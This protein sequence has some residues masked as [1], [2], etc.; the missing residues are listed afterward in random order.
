[1]ATLY[2][3]E[4]RAQALDYSG[5]AVPVGKEPSTA[6]QI[7]AIGVASTPSAAFQPTTR[8][9]RLH[10]DAICSVAFGP[11]PV[12]TPNNARMAAGQTEF[13]GVLG[14]QSVAAIVNT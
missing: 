2:I 11:A 8:F 4:Y 13:W 3:S 7:V 9:V 10:T 14:G 6:T 1:V 12:A 5:L